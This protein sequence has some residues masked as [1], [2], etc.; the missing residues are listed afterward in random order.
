[1]DTGRAAFTTHDVKGDGYA[2]EEVHDETSE[3]HSTDSEEGI[4]DG[5]YRNR[6]YSLKRRNKRQL[7]EDLIM[8]VG[9]H[10]SDGQTGVDGDSSRKFCSDNGPNIMLITSIALTFIGLGLDDLSGCSIS[11]TIMSLV[12]CIFQSFYLIE[13]M[14]DGA[15]RPHIHGVP[16]PE[17]H[18]LAGNTPGQMASTRIA[19]FAGFVVGLLGV[20]FAIFFMDMRL[21]TKFYMF[22]TTLFVLTTSLAKWIH[23]RD[24]FEAEIWHDE[25]LGAD[26]DHGRS[27]LSSRAEHALRNLHNGQTHTNVMLKGIYFFSMVF[28]MVILALMYLWFATQTMHMGLVVGLTAFMLSLG[29]F[30]GKWVN[31]SVADSYAEVATKHFDALVMPCFAVCVIGTMVAV[32]V[33]LDF[34]GFHRK[35]TLAVALLCL[36]NSVLNFSKAAHKQA[37]LRLLLEVLEK[38][39]N[40]SLEFGDRVDLYES[41]FPADGNQRDFQQDPGH[42]GYGAQQQGYGNDPYAGQQQGGQQQYDQGG[43]YGH[44]QGRQQGG[45]Y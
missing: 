32:F 25:V 21:D 6:W 42:G 11:Y 4:A 20:L 27:V 10:V 37:N 43:Q 24:Q 9:D 31:R 15:V 13:L 12:M 33:F 7:C 30:F 44:G 19:S 17:V 34:D 39:L 22:V 18:F 28:C 23:D 26:Q 38:R 3:E 45:G 41:F 29:W 40:T 36:L 2:H 35:F 1:M 5:H 14:R 16:S 8:V